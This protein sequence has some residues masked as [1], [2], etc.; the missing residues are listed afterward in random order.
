MSKFKFVLIFFL[1]FILINLLTSFLATK[2]IPYLG[3]FPYKDL[4]TQYQL[5]SFIGSFANFDGTHYLAIAGMGYREFEQAFFPLYPLLIRV[6]ALALNINYLVAGLIISNVAFFF[7]LIFIFLFLTKL[8]EKN[9]LLWFFLFL[10][11]FPTSFFFSA[12]YTEG[13]FFFLIVGAL[14]FLQEKKYWFLALFAFLA[15]ATRVI[16]IFLV[17]PIIFSF[18][19]GKTKKLSFK[20]LLVLVSPLS[21]LL[22]YS[23]YLFKTTGDPLF[24]FNTQPLFGAHRSTNI[25]LLPQVYYRYLKIFFSAQWNFQYF[26]SLVEFL[27]FNFVLFFLILDLVKHLRI[28]KNNYQRL[29]LNIFSL[30]TLILPTLTGT[31]S[32][33]PRYALFSLSLF[34]M[35][36]QIKNNVVKTLIAVGFLILHSVLLAFFIQG[37]FVS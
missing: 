17:V 11:L 19:F 12:V 18:W 2:M 1:L 36:S 25:I 33:I 28:K 8:L 26:I 3:F 14:Y 9:D 21:G 15:S 30:I 16:G 27:V 5:P 37:Y 13:L 10:I 23:F 34:F 32:S 29:G 4:I 35:L 24:F 20:K 22:A 7:G 31:F 6:V